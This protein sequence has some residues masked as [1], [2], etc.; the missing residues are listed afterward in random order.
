MYRSV[1]SPVPVEITVNM[2]RGQQRQSFPVTLAVGVNV[3]YS[4]GYGFNT[5]KVL[6]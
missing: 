5:C 1:V 2:L 6:Y 3:E 4:Y